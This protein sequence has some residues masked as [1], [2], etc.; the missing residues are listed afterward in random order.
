M[1]DMQRQRLEAALSDARDT[2]AERFIRYREFLELLGGDRGS[3]DAGT[4]EILTSAADIQQIEKRQMRNWAERGLDPNNGRVGIVY[5]DAVSVVVAHPIRTGDG[6]IERTWKAVYWWNGL[7]GKSVALVP[8]TD[9]GRV[10][11]VPAWRGPVV[12]RW[13]L[14][15]PGGGDVKATEEIQAVRA[16]MF[17]EAGYEILEYVRLGGDEHFIVDPSTNGTPIAL[18][19]VRLGEKGGAHPE[20]GEILRP[21]VLM[22]RNDLEAAF[23]RGYATLPEHP[24]RKYHLLDGRNGICALMAIIYN[25]VR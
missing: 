12:G 15:F 11:L 7:K 17:E 24:E 22:N 21:P 4:H 5:E 19:A 16:E 9:D 2:R 3:A 14:E 13:E 23:S 25:F 8:Y 18:Y 10:L 1:D 20:A 6:K